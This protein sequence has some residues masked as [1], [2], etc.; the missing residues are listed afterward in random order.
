MVLLEYFLTFSKKYMT[1]VYDKSIQD[2]VHLLT[3]KQKGPITG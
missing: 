1:E 2:T 3:K